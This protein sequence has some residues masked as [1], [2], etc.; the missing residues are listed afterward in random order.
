MLRNRFYVLVVSGCLACASA[1]MGEDR[2]GH[3]PLPR[4]ESFFGLH[5]DL[6]PGPGDP[7]LGADVTEE[8]VAKLLT[9]VRPN[10]VQYDSKGHGGYLG[11]P[12]SIGPSAPHMTRD[13]L[14]IWR[15]VT[16][17]HGVALYIHFS[18]L[19][20]MAALANNP[21]WGAMNATGQRDTNNTSVFSPYVDQVM[22]PQLVEAAT[23]YDLDGAWVDGECWAARWDY[24]PEAL[25]AWKKETGFDQAP[26]NR[27]Q[28]NWLEWKRFNRRHFEQYVGH[29]VDAVHAARPGFQ[30]ASNWLYTTLTPWPVRVKVDFVSGDYDPTNSVDRA[31]PE[32]RYTASTTMPWDLMAWGFV[33]N[34]AGMGQNIKPAVHLQQEAAVVLMQGGGFQIYYQPTRK[35]HIADAVIETTGRVADFCRLRQTVSHKSTSIPQVALL[36]S[37]AVIEDRS[38]SVGA[39]WGSFPELVGTLHALLELHYSVDILA[40]HQIKGRL[41]DYPCIVVPDYDR[42]ANGMKDEILAYVRDGGRLLLVGTAAAR[43]FEPILGVK[44]EGQ[45]QEVPAEL[46]SPHGIGAIN[47]PW[48][49]VTLQRAE[50]V[51]WRYPTRDTRKDGEIAATVAR[52]ENG[53]VGA[54]YGPVGLRFL[55]LH[56]PYLREF[57]G[58]VV[59]RVFPEPA[60]T[61]SGPPCLDVA[62]RRTRNGQPALHFLNRANVPTSNEYAL[63]D[64]V[65]PVGPI[66]VKWRLPV[67]PQK[68]EWVPE[69]G[70][71]EWTWSDGVL[72]VTLPRVD[73][74]G[75]LIA[76]P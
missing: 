7:A 24:S 30:V 4:A 75:V 73:V 41:K 60:F 29:W 31:R 76:Q 5:F 50:A 33:N 38:D 21:E 10:Y 48:Q 53:I 69:G 26:T 25:A 66:S 63:I 62:L 17:D 2:A 15:K 72:S 65:P 54:I 70:V 27:N 64:Y 13:S 42:F 11:W 1:S 55:H 19:F 57:I 28:P 74:H 37:T 47:G 32:A 52:H 46:A 40:E 22:I 67:K 16:R 14:Q 44:L 49:K 34:L 43:Q 3:R 71:G 12:S 45:P 68:L 35:G 8:M 20:D 18:G 39:A 51:G 6:H 61:V 23:K 56:S 59:Q 58:Q 9:R 36:M